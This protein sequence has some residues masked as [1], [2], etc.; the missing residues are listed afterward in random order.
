[1]SKYKVLISPQAYEELE[2]I[3]KY[4]ALSLLSSGAANSTLE[5]IKNAIL[6]LDEIPNRGAI[7]KSWQICQY[8][9]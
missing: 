8:G 2:A 7:R 5:A 3:Y 9:L 1:M 4:I 6:S